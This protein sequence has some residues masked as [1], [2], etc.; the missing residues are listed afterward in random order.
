[1]W[2]DHGSGMTNL[3]SSVTRT[4]ITNHPATSPHVGRRRLELPTNGAA[5]VPLQAASCPDG[6][7]TWSQ[8]QP[9]VGR[10]NMRRVYRH[11]GCFH[12]FHYASDAVIP[13]GCAAH[14]GPMAS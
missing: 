4:T 10:V 11:H 5:S 2:P 1:M 3:A 13:A 12:L 9:A 7:G 14:P 6:Y 8:H